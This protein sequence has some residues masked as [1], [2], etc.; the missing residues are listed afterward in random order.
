MSAHK[1]QW[2][3]P[4]DFPLAGCPHEV[5]YTQD[6]GEGVALPSDTPPSIVVDGKVVELAA[7]NH[8]FDSDRCP[9]FYDGCN[10]HDVIEQ[11]LDVAREVEE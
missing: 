4:H 9:W 6:V 3:L 1:I 8:G 11:L 10:C 7:I 2:C 5:H